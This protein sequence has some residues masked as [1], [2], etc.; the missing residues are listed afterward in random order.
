MEMKITNVM[1]E[2]K[3]L[4]HKQPE[5]V[6]LTDKDVK[7]TYR[8]V[9]VISDK[10]AGK[11]LD[12]T[13]GK[14]SR[15]LLNLNHNC[16]IIICIIAVLKTGNS[17]IP[18]I[19]DITDEK[20]EY[21]K[22]C[23]GAK[24]V[25]AEKNKNI[26]EQNIILES[27]FDTALCEKEL[28]SS[29]YHNDDEVYVLFTSGSTGN[30]KGVSIEYGNLLYILNNMQ[31]ICPTDSTSTYAFSTPYTFDVSVTEI[32]SWINGGQ[33]SVIDLATYDDFKN[34]P[35]FMSEMKITHLA[36][37]PS[38]FTNMLRV[39]SANETD[40]L[41]IDLKYLMIAG[42][43]FKKKVF[44]EWEKNSWK[45]RL[46]NL[47][48]PTEATVYALGYELMHGEAYEENIPI[49]APLDGCGY[50]IDNPD[51]NGVGELVLFGSGI[52]RKYI[53]NEL[54]NT[55]KFRENNG[56]R[57]YRTGDLAC[58]QNGNVMYHGRNDDQVQ[59]NGI[60]V[61]LGEIEYLI[62]KD[63]RILDVCVAAYKNIIL[64]HIVLSEKNGTD[65][66]SI[67]N[68]LGKL[69]PRYMIPNYIKIVDEL[70]LNSNKKAEKEFVVKEYLELKNRTNITA[71][72][73]LPIVENVCEIMSESLDNMTVN[74]CDDYFEL[75]ADSLDVFALVAALED[76]YEIDLNIDAVYLY[77]TPEKIANYIS[78][79]A[80]V[81]SGKGTSKEQKIEL[82]QTTVLTRK[83]HDFIYDNKEDLVR[84]YKTLYLQQMYYYNNFNSFIAFDF[85]LG[86]KYSVEE[87]KAGILKLMESNP[88]LRAKIAPKDDYLLFE[89]Y[90]FEEC[91]LIPEID[92]EEGAFN[93]IKD[94]I[95]SN[96]LSEMFNARYNGGFMSLFTI[97]RSQ[98]CFSIIFI[99]DH[100]V[101]DGSCENLLKNQLIN[102]LNHTENHDVKDYKTYCEHVIKNV[103]IDNLEKNWYF[104]NLKSCKI[105]NK[106][107][108]I[109]CLPSEKCKLVIKNVPYTDNTKST[110]VVA[111]L[112]SGAVKKI[113]NC[114]VA[115][116]ALF[117]IREFEKYQYKDTIGD[118]H[119]GMSFVNKLGMNLNNFIDEA[120]QTIEL[121]TKEP[122]QPNQAIEDTFPK[123]NEQQ[124]KFKNVMLGSNI[125]SVNYMGTISDEELKK[126][127]LSI[128]DMQEHLYRI[129]KQIYVTAYN[130]RGDIV[131]YFNKKVC[132]GN[133]VY[134]EFTELR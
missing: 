36:L 53:N 30:P 11:I 61:E 21:I 123:Y 14:K 2:F 88:I 107:T 131:I 91:D 26:I 120:H 57:E 87:I 66:E 118:V 97:V 81:K 128:Y 109:S 92:V 18:T 35:D 29:N 72:N 80:N 126:V 50:Y 89:E 49:G 98:N 78:Q 110:L 69:M 76:K 100:C 127:E 103:S 32:Y 82:E 12:Y 34:F 9:D 125:F 90:K 22:N 6:F 117:N 130:N 74:N 48:G 83:V 41:V 46:F 31:N 37:S 51:V 58:E 5:K 59:L 27:E 45:F 85:D 23:T 65:L 24:V 106:E 95:K 94:F 102:I 60:R 96:Y 25:I 79:A 1:T 43:A 68:N 54:E 133:T 124:Q 111:Y 132:D 86:L 20:M 40:K 33:I 84:K 17:Y 119:V 116:R 122:F 67:K 28:K 63:K 114:N 7:L 19:P 134:L 121:F 38:G 129:E 93:N 70:T 4:V 52:A 75:G 112:L 64:A 77:R 15:I 71:K 62:R 115:V 10:L 39:Y 101:S 16:K 73:D 42:E 113:T 105:E 13:K 56:Q 47:Y 104:E 55:K 8:E 99:L 108:L 44:D 3:N